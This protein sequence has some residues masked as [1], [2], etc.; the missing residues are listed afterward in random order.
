M[1]YLVLVR[2]LWN[3]EAAWKTLQREFNNEDAAKEYAKEMYDSANTARGEE[4]A[5]MIYELKECYC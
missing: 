3:K 5:V 1:K 4:I 2:Y